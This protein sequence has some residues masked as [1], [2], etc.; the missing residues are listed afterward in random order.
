M[1][2][3]ADWNREP[4][5]EGMTGRRVAGGPSRPAGW[6]RALATAALSDTCAILLAAPRPPSRHAPRPGPGAAAA[7]PGH[8]PR[9]AI[10]AHAGSDQNTR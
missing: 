8:A 2:G 3:A 1:P 5:S 7:P 4:A 10:N 6:R 9:A